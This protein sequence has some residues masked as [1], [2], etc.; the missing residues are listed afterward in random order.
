MQE[1]M[2]FNDVAIFSVKGNCYRIHFSGMSK[3]EAI[4]LLRFPDLS[5]KVQRYKT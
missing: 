5:Q 4:N 3:S 1:A 2:I